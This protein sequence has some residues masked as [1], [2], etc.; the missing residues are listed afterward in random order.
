M[1]V[2]YFII[3]EDSGKTYIGF[4]DNIARRLCEHKQGKVKTTKSF[5]KIRCCILERIENLSIARKRE[6]YWK[7]G[8]GRKKIKKNFEKLKNNSVAVM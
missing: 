5:V 2:I 1:Y 6:R 7:A 8:S 4:S 3:D